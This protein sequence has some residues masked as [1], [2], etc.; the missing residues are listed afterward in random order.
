MP[1]KNGQNEITGRDIYAQLMKFS[2]TNMFGI[3]D[4]YSE[5]LPLHNI[6]SLQTPLIDISETW[7]LC[8]KTDYSS[9]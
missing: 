2:Q 9:V 8:Y 4:L 1:N 3:G 7:T 5:S 6:K